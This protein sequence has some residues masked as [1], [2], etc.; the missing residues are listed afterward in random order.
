MA[1]LAVVFSLACLASVASAQQP[2]S[3]GRPAIDSGAHVRLT[4]PSPGVRFETGRL[5]A[6]TADSVIIF[7]DRKLSRRAFALADVARLEVGYRPRVEGHPILK[8]F[9][10]GTAAGAAPG[11]ALAAVEAGT[12]ENECGWGLLI[13]MVG[14]APGA[15]IGTLIGTA[16]VGERWR[17]V[18]LPTP[19]RVGVVPLP[20]GRVG[21][22]FA[23]RF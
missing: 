12:C 8:G 18:P 10:L 23:L 22:G 6:L 14:A 11:L 17:P 9:L 15:V 3:T 13:A 19:A 7:S 4:A 2:D 21:A 1:R 16:R 5:L 20:A